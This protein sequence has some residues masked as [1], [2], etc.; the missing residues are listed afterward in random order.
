MVFGRFG[1][2]VYTI[3]VDVKDFVLRCSVW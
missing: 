2:V 1:L 3:K